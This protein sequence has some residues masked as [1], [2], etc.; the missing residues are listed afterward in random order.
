MR[1]LIFVG[2]G[3]GACAAVFANAA[4]S[5]TRPLRVLLVQAVEASPMH[6]AMAH[7]FGAAVQEALAGG[8]HT[9]TTV[10]IEDATPRDAAKEFTARR[11]DG[12][13][14]LGADRPRVLRKLT[15]TT[16]VGDL[17]RAF[18]YD[19]ISLLVAEEDAGTK[20][21]LAAAFAIAL[22]RAQT[23]PRLLAGN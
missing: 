20:K 13:V 16:L 17:G 11:C 21:K 18:C 12:V 10:C 14:V 15:A 1:T 8:S 4:P 3:I 22:K 6:L 5:E 7:G 9:G 19:S 2:L 23:E